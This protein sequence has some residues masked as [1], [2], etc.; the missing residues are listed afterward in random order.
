M[1][2]P[3]EYIGDGSDDDL[4]EPIAIKND[5][6]IELIKNTEQPDMLN[7]RMVLEEEIDGDKEEMMS[8]AVA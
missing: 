5:V 1:A 6:L 4:L 8:V 2:E 3:P 7:V